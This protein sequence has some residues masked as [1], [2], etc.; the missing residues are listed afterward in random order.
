MTIL[1][2]IIIAIL[3][4]IIVI[5][6]KNGHRVFDSSSKEKELETR[7][8]QKENEGLLQI[9]N[10]L[11]EEREKAYQKKLS[12][13]E[14]LIKEQNSLNNYKENK[15]AS[16]EYEIN[17]YREQQLNIIKENL[18]AIDLIE[19]QKIESNVEQV[20]LQC[21]EEIIALKEQ[22]CEVKEHLDNLYAKRQNTLAVIKE[23]E[24]IKNEVDFYRVMLKKEDVEDIEQLKSIERKLNNKDVLRKLIYKTFIESQMNLMFARVGIT[25]TAGVYKITNIKN[26]MCYIGQS[27]NVK[28]RVKAHI[29]AAIGISTIASQVVHDKMA[30]EGLDNFTFQLVEECDKTQLNDREKYFINYY[31]SNE[32]GYNKTSGG[33]RA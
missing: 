8:R 19:K 23:E 3:I 25:E 11:K 14:E 15:F 32:Y 9:E 10:N 33:A 29:Q 12:I 6:L 13:N 7:L 2:Y 27:T 22:V 1:L 4:F 16:V 26:N 24:K 30:E 20:R 17:L 21:E 31:S 28:N 5:L 18:I